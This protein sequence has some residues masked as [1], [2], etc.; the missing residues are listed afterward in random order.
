MAWCLDANNQGDTLMIERSHSLMQHLLFFV[1]SLVMVL[2]MRVA[3]AADI[4]DYALPNTWTIKNE[5]LIRNGAGVREY[6]FFKINVYAAALY[7]P[8]HETSAMAILR[9]TLPRVIHLKMLRDVSR[10][11]TISAWRHYLNE[12]CKLPCM[13]DDKARML[14]DAILTDTKA[15]DTQTYVFIEGKVEIWRN[16]SKQGEITDAL[17]ANV[18]LATWIGETPTT[19]ALKRALL[20]ATRE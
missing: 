13:L 12:N 19:D 17:F 4:V 18:L 3:M 10:K 7:L 11:D 5:T 2:T 16:G 8:K 1:F 20:R 15:S 14:F 9:S 6:G